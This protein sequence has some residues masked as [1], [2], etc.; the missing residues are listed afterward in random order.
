MKIFL[1]NYI[2]L[3]Y[4]RNSIIIISKIIGILFCIYYII[5]AKYYQIEWSLWNIFSWTNGFT[6][7]L[8]KF[9]AYILIIPLTILISSILHSKNIWL[10]TVSSMFGVTA[11]LF[12]TMKM[13]LIEI[14]EKALT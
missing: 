6:N 1:N 4:F 13:I 3:L 11:I 8:N 10:N 14:Q 12:S 5:N 9:G 7:L 2:T